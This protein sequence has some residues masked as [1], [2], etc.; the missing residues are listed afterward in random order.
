MKKERKEEKNLIYYFLSALNICFFD[1]EAMKKISI[2]SRA[3]IFAFI[4]IILEGI[5]QAVGQKNWW[6]MAVLPILGLLI[7]PISAGIMHGIARLFRGKAHYIN[8]LRASGFGSLI[9][10][11]FVFPLKE[12]ALVFL[13]LFLLLWSIAIDTIIVSEIYKIKKWQSG[14]AVIIQ[15]AIMIVI[16]ALITYATGMKA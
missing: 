9:G 5:A 6:G 14:T 13:T 11:L 2:D 3:T 16:L 4:I 1:K 15:T 12:N 8:L 10:V 7:F